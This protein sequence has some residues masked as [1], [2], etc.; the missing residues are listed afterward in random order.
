[1]KKK[2]RAL[3]LLASTAVLSFN[4]HAGLV[5][6]GF[7]APSFTPGVPDWTLFSEGVIPGWQTTATDNQIEL[8]SDS[9][10]GVAAY[11]GTQFAE[12]NANL[13]ST[14]YQDV[15]GIAAGST[16]GF[17][18]A[19]RGRQGVDTM[20]LTITDLGV[21]NLIGG[22]NDTVLFT[23]QYSDG[24]AAWGFYTNP[25]PYTA[26]G[27]TIRFAYESVS[28][29]GGNPAIGNFIDAADFGVGV[30]LVPEP[31]TLSMFLAGLPL[32]LAMRRRKAAKA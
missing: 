19:H 8:W 20:R 3:T 4:A 29:A 22:G 12:L 7:E 24:N 18:F 25:E 11:E 31:A 15:S 1:M 13:V 9:F 23:Q 21:D 30:G 27:N 2:I 5:N 32:S 26:L 16:I 14:L 28:A 6:G 17:Q 10:N